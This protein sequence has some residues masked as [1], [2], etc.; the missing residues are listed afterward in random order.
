MSEISDAEVLLENGA[1]KLSINSAAVRQPGIITDLAKRY[2]SQFVVVAV[3]ARFENGNWEVYVNGGRKPT[4]KE[5]FSWVREAEERGA[6]EI[7]FTSMNHDGTKNG[8]AVEALKQ[9]ALDVSIPVIAS[10]GAGEKVHF[11]ELFENSRAEAALAA[12]IF[13]YGEIPVHSLKKYLA[14]EGVPVRV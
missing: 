14:E 9:M 13:H 1:D 3:D 12:S 7:L 8:Y 5:L 4:G 2:G 6:G 11:K 10:G